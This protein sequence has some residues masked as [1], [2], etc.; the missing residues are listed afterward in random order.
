MRECRA[1]CYV[2]SAGSRAKTAGVAQR[3]S[4]VNSAREIT[5]IFLPMSK[6]PFNDL[7]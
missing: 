4:V 1:L 5:L 2:S 3:A 7:L 6:V